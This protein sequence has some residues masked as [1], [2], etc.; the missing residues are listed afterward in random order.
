MATLED[1]RN[2]CSA[3]PG[4]MEG[5]G[6]FGF[7][8]EVKGKVKGFVW[9]WMERVQPKKPKVENR[10]V[11][12]IVTPGLGAKEVLMASAPEKYVEDPHYN[13]YPAVLA[14]IEAFDA[15]ELRDLLEEAW[16]CKAAVEKRSRP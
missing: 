9:S 12:A 15:D 14:R 3:L 6:Q 1:V 5:D 10:D 7:G 8:V 13:G 2:I 11:L 16:R 4:A